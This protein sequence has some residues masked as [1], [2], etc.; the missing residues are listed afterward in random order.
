MNEMIYTLQDFYLHTKGVTYL[1]MVLAL[2]G[3]AGFW[4]FLT[5]RDDD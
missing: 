4:C 5:A 2:F 1:L 3:V